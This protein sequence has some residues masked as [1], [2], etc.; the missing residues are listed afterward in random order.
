MTAALHVSAIAEHLTQRDVRILHDLER[1]RLLTTRHIQRLHFP[2]AP[3]GPHVTQSGATRGTTRVLGRLEALGVIARL[4]RRIGGIKHGSAVT[5]WQLGPA[6]DR[7]LRARR[8]ERTRRRFHE[9]GHL[10]THHMLAVADV[11]ITL[12]EHANAG[13]FELLEL[14]TEPACWRTFTSGTGT[15]TLKPD[16]FTVTADATTETHSFIEVDLGSEHRPAIVRKCQTYQR[17]ALQGHEQ[18]TR[19]LFPAVVWITPHSARLRQIRDAIR[20]DPGLD[21]SLF[22]VTTPET[23]LQ[24][25]APYTGVTT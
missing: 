23:M 18:H 3:L 19:G 1:F 13:R 2:A 25:L 21:H 4:S 22:W 9:P 6:G 14:E 16:L 24:Q 12:I 11:A 5:I 17:Y 15:L 8:G 20:S 7:F 10:F